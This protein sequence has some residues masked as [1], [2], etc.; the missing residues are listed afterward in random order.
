MECTVLHAQHFQSLIYSTMFNLPE[1]RRVAARRPT[2]DGAT[3]YHR[4]VLQVLQSEY[5]G[6]WQLKSPQYG[7][8][9]DALFETY[10]DARLVVTHRDPVK[11]AASTFSLLALSHRHVHRRRPH[12]VHRVALA[13]HALD[14]A[15][16]RHGCARPHRRGLVLRRRLRRHRARSGRGRR[17]IYERFGIE[18]NPEKEEYFRKFHADNPQH[19]YGTHTYSLA[20][21]GVER[22]SLDHASPATTSATTC[23]RRKREL[24][25]AHLRDVALRRA[26]GRSPRSPSTD[27]RCATPS[28]P[29]GPRARRRVAALR[30]GRRHPRRRP[31]RHAAGLL[32]RRRPVARRRDVRRASTPTTFIAAGLRF[33]PWEVRKPVIAAVNGH[34]IGVGLTL[35]IQCDLRFMAADAKYGVVQVRRGV[36]GDAFVHWSL[37]RIVGHGERGRDPP[38]RAGRS[39]AHE[40]LRLGVASRVP[41]DRRGAAGGVGVRA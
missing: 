41:A 11:I 4:Q 13:R 20:E 30:R 35:A 3:R 5:P 2:W 24:R 40:M 10:P 8:L 37:P 6:R 12:R 36:M 32:R 7:L 33:P 26:R 17:D 29:H 16:P 25:N 39:T 27:P 38:H 23:P 19:K 31:H 14:A 15:R 21:V 34:A 9:L 18:W 22:G 1:L 28:A